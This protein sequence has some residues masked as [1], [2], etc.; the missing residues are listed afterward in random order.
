LLVLVVGCGQSDAPTSPPAEAG[1]PATLTAALVQAASG[2]G[3]DAEFTRLAQR[4]PGFGGMYFDRSGRLTVHMKAA[5]GA[6]TL[7]SSDVAGELRRAGGAAV[8]RRLA[9]GVQVVT[10]AAK[11]DYGELQNYRARLG[12]VL[13]LRGVVY[14]DTDE[15]RNRI[16]IALEPGASQG[17]VLR[18]VDRAGVPREAVVMTRMSKIKALKTLQDRFRPVPGGAQIVFPAPSEGPGALF[19]CSLGF[20]ARIPS[21][22]NAEFFVTAAHCSDIQGGNQNTPYFQP[23]PFTATTAANRIAREFRDPELGNPGGLCIYEGARCRLSDALLARYTDPDFSQ[24]GKIARTTFGLARIGSLEIDPDHPRWQVADEFAFPFLG[25][26]AHKVG[27]SSGWT[28]GPVI[29]TC[30]DVGVDGTDIVDICQDIVLAGVRGGDSGSGVFERLGGN[31]IALVGVL[32]GGGDLD[33]A[34]VFVFSA[35]ENI[36]QELGPLTTFP[37]SMLA[38]Q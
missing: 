14:I 25:E 19:V 13:K 28:S 36:E 37:G 5:P 20:N 32:W 34:P 8:Q 11:Y 31:R 4:V 23:D 27:R 29:V 7:R 18:E 17:P 24:F 6:A 2:R 33:G 12:R 35:M 1:A 10:V 16:G 38:A 3:I 22:P 21:H 9:S 15:E 26:T 30:V